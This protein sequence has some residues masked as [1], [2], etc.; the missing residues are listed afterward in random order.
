MKTL[1]IITF[2]LLYSLAIAQ[3][4]VVTFES[5]QN[6][7]KGTGTE[8]N[9]LK[10]SLFE[11]ASGDFPF[12]YERV[13]TNKISA[14]VSAGVTFG[15]YYGSIF[16]NSEISPLESSVDAKYGFSLSAGLRFYPIEALEDFYISPE[17]KFRKYNWSREID[18]FSDS[19]NG[20]V[21]YET[22]DESRTYAMPRITLG[23][24]YFYDYNIIVDWH[25]GVG[26]NTP[27]ETIF[28]FDEHVVLKDKQNTRPRIHFGLKI[29]Y[30]F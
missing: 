6:E 13:L 7:E 14:E 28:N 24:S 30:L 19:P 29:G 16:S 1:L 11:L 25:F 22:I 8:V 21:I 12:Y 23:Y 4:R 15:D 9:V 10:V 17:F 2:T 5:E 20:G 27:T 18:Y 26:M 3:P